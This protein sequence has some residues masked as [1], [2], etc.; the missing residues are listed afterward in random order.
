MYN[1]LMKFYVI[2]I[3]LITIKNI[4]PHYIQ[5][6]NKKICANCKFFIKNKNECNKFGK[7]DMITGDYEYEKA[8][9]VR[10]DENKCGN[11]GIF[12]EK[13]YVKYISIPFNFLFDNFLLIFFISYIIILLYI[14]Y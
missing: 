13:N 10:E 5:N 7:I 9:S 12:F 8:I 4:N 2:S 14:N 1:I 6:Q 11:D 3:F